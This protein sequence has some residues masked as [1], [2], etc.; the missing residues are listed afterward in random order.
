MFDESQELKL[1]ERI[2]LLKLR[3]LELE[4][5]EAA[6]VQQQP[7]IQSLCKCKAKSKSSLN[8]VDFALTASYPLIFGVVRWIYSFV[9]RSKK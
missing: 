2:D 7:I 4:I 3:I 8:L 1:R 9:Y 5:I 6:Y